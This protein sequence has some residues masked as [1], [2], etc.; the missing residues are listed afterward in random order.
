MLLVRSGSFSVLDADRFGETAYGARSRAGQRPFSVLDADRFGETTSRAAAKRLRVSFSVLD[1]DRFGETN[2]E[3][4]KAAC[5]V[6]FSVLDADRFGETTVK[7]EVCFWYIHLSVSSM[8]T[9]SV[10]QQE[11]SSMAFQIIFQCPRCGPVR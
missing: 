2:S 5:L 10:K 4:H 1:A 6:A 3:G 11:A 7:V 9:G 8:R